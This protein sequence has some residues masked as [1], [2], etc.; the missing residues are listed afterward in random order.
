LLHS[1]GTRPDREQD[2]PSAPEKEAG[3]MHRVIM[4]FLLLL[5]LAPAPAQSDEFQGVAPEGTDAFLTMSRG[6]ASA[7][8]KL[9]DANP[10]LI[11]ARTAFGD[12]LLHWAASRELPEVAELLLRRGA[13]VDARDNHGTTP[14]LLAADKDAIQVVRLLVAHGADLRARDDSGRT[15]LHAAA[16][17]PSRSKAEV[18][19]LLIARGAEV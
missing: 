1:G 7:V 10:S 8:G 9:L 2:A 16:G 11:T 12:T 14:L 18:A 4:A 19:A 3:Y 13:E 15:P 6:D 17:V 5:P